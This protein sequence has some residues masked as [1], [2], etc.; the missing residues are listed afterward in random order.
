MH[1]ARRAH[2][3]SRRVLSAAVFIMFMPPRLRAHRRLMLAP[4]VLFSRARA[5]GATF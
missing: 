1:A 3:F 5:R 4:Y 2:R